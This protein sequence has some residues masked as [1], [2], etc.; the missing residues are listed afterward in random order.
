V[1][2][3]SLSLLGLVGGNESSIVYANGLFIASMSSAV[4]LPVNSITLSN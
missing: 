1:G 3:M 2:N 4:G